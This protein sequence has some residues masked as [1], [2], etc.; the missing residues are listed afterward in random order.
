MD[1]LKT[2]ETEPGSATRA[3]GRANLSGQN[4]GCS[5]VLSYLPTICLSLHL[6]QKHCAQSVTAK[7]SVN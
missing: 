1:V 7:L 2:A 4:I 3:H 5:I 6:Y